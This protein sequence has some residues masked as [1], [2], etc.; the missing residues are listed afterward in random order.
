MPESPLND[1][2]KSS[3]HSSTPFDATLIGTTVGRPYRLF[4]RGEQ[5]ALRNLVAREEEIFNSNNSD[6]EKIAEFENVIEPYLLSGFSDDA[7]FPPVG[8]GIAF[9]QQFAE[10]SL[11]LKD[12]MES[13]N[14]ALHDSLA[15]IKESFPFTSESMLAR[16]HGT[17]LPIVQG[18]MTG[19]TA[20]HVLAIEVSRQGGLPFVSTAALSPKKSRDL[21]LKTREAL[22]KHPFGAGLVLFANPDKMEE[23]VKAVLSAG[24]DFVT[25]AGPWNNSG[26]ALSPFFQGPATITQKSC[27]Q[28][29][30]DI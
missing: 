14:A 3:L 23:Q 2:W 13:Y 22:G 16:R 19:V 9:A 25:I 20:K 21:I 26:K 8:Q 5:Q 6:A 29:R 12:V 27:G 10:D 18:P 30:R 15:R 17:K 24:P 4:S 28:G 11:S 7:V 1:K